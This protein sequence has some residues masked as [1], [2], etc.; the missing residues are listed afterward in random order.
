MIRKV[1][2]LGLI[3]TLLL[4]AVVSTQTVNFAKADPYIPNYKKVGEIS[5]PNGTILPAVIIQF[6]KNDTFYPSNN[7]SLNFSIANFSI[8]AEQSNISLSVT[9]LSY[10]ESWQKD[11]V[12][13]DLLSLFIQNGYRLPHDFSINLTN[14]PEGNNWLEINATATGIAYETNHQIEGSFY[15][16]Y[17]VGYAASCSAIVQFTVDTTAPKIL[18]VSTENKTY[19]T[20]RVPLTVLTSEPTSRIVYSLDGQPPFTSNENI[21][22]E[23]ANGN[24]NLTITP[25]DLAGNVGQPNTTFFTIANPLAS[26]SIQI[27]TI[28]LIATALITIVLTIYRKKRST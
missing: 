23:L 15:T 9:E 18:S 6:P 5:P 7:L 12:D 13:I 1:L 3:V 28:A 25:I 2:W 19:A 17:Y 14:I 26:Q 20:S 21:T 4:P 16:I 10:K 11:R 22:L 8:T 27:L 24:H